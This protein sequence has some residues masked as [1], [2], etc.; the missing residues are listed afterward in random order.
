MVDRA[1][2]KPLNSENDDGVRKNNNGVGTNDDGVREYNGGAGTNDDGVRKNNDG[3]E[4]TASRLSRAAR[5]FASPP[6]AVD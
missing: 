5:G 3:V 4:S 2:L 6:R 1:A